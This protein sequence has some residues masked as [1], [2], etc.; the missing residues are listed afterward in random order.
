MAV[1]EGERFEDLPDEEI[2]RLVQTLNSLQE[3][4]LG[5]A[6]LVACGQR[7]VGPLRDFLLHGRPSGVAEPRQ[8]AVRA[9]AELNAADVL[10]E[11]LRTPKGISDPVVRLGE[12]A[13]ENTAAR[14]LAKWPTEEVFEE[15]LYLLSRRTLSGVIETLSLFRRPE[16]IPY[17]ITALG[18]DIGRLPAEDALRSLGEIA[19]PALAEA[20]RTPDPSLEN[21]SPSSLLR[22]RCAARI[23]AENDLSAELWPKLQPLLYDRDI[24]IAASTARIAFTADAHGVFPLAV[25]RAMDALEH[26]HWLTKVEVE[27]CLVEHFQAV[28][29]FVEAEIRRREDGLPRD[30]WARDSVRCSLHRIKSRA[31]QGK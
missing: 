11:Y 22:R 29:A 9:L 17:F 31:L 14:A 5:I 13:V 20:A 10:V 24:E 18:D 27:D 3:G 30:R 8:R 15:L 7:A 21:E 26:A 28:E 25:R 4:E 23:L 16:P 1:N 19:W 2:R 6:M 12:E